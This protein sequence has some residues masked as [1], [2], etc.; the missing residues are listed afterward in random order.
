MTFRIYYSDGT[1]YSG[2][3]ELAPGW[4]VVVIPQ[5]GDNWWGHDFAGLLDCLA[6]PNPNVVVIGRTVSKADW[7]LFLALADQD[8]DFPPQEGRTIM[9]S[10]DFY[11]WHGDL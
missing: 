4:G 6:Q 10:W 3:P 5:Y 11:C 8:P 7:A 1:T 2:P 9:H